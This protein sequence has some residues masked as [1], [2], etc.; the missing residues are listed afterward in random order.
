MEISLKID[1]LRQNAMNL[2]EKYIDKLDADHL[3]TF[4]GLLTDEKN[5]SI[6]SD[7]FGNDVRYNLNL[8]IEIL[9]N[10]ESRNVLTETEMIE[11]DEICILSLKVMSFNKKI[12]DL[13]LYKNQPYMITDIDVDDYSLHI[14]Y[15][16]DENGFWIDF[17]EVE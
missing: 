6:E 16:L 4:E 15:D 1:E 3:I 12:G 17:D 14:S 2:I 11:F 13:I 9:T 10:L 7:F 5:L 8:C